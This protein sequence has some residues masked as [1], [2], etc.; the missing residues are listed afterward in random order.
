LTVEVFLILF[1]VGVAAG[2]L[3]GLFG[4]GGGIV[5]VPSL[6]A[7]YSLI[8]FNSPYA[9]HVAIATSLFSII[10]TST[11]SAYT[12]S[13]HGN[14]LW[15]ASL[16]IGIASTVTIF[17]FSKMAL[18]LPGDVLKKIFAA[19]LIVIGIKMLIEK[20]SGSEEEDKFSNQNT[21]KIYY[22]L[23]GIFAGI[24]AAFTGLGGGI[25]VIPLLHY[26]LKVPIRKSIGTSAAA[27]FITSLSGVISYIINSPAG[28][29]TM[30]Y[31]LGI[32]DTVSAIPIVLASIPFAQ[33][34]VYVNKKIKHGIIKKLFAGLI[35]IVAIKMLFF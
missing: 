7:V 15:I 31:S 19:V 8:G 25:F 9:V 4:V 23:T 6:L 24:I 21:N 5:I 20:N 22:L 17:L 29:D 2:I 12:H 28:A 34:G 1:G 14:V 35:L 13:T 11:S 10:F 33:V 3:S 32:V 16:L 18:A 26:I 27:I 30:K